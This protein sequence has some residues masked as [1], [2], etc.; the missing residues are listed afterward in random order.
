[1]ITSL[2]LGFFEPAVTVSA[3]SRSRVAS[4][5]GSQVTVI[6]PSPMPDVGVMLTQLISVGMAALQAPLLDTFT[7][8]VP[9]AA[10]KVCP[11]V[12]NDMVISCLPFCLTA[13]AYVL[14]PRLP[15][16]VMCR[17]YR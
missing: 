7:F 2:R 13:M 10:V 12:S 16:E 5:L 8:F 17:A 4:L 14:A 6:S 9:P 11:V 3:V 1:M 15:A